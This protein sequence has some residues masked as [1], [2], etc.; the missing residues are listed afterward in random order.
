MACC[1]TRPYEIVRLTPEVRPNRCLL[2][3]KQ[4]TPMWVD[5]PPGP[6]HGGGTGRSSSSPL[7]GSCLASGLRRRDLSEWTTQ[8]HCTRPPKEVGECGSSPQA[9]TPRPYEGERRVRP[10]PGRP[11]PVYA[12]PPRTGERRDGSERRSRTPSAAPTRA[13]ATPTTPS[14]EARRQP[15]PQQA[16]T[17]GAAG[18][19]CPCGTCACSWSSEPKNLCSLCN[20][21]AQRTAITCLCPSLRAGPWAEISFNVR[22]SS[23][24]RLPPCVGRPSL[25]LTLSPMDSYRL[26]LWRQGLDLACCHQVEHCIIGSSLRA[27]EGGAT[28]AAALG[29][30]P[31]VRR[32]HGDQLPVRRVLYSVCFARQS[33]TWAAARSRRRPGQAAAARIHAPP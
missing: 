5:R 8:F 4:T 26:A 19:N 20:A 23:V 21:A 22:R 9:P 10:F 14:S 18:Q 6:V 3:S 7:G 30:R 29:R 15:A 12:L 28:L 2:R 11:Y 17:A 16:G 25:V 27:A 13:I 32:H 1:C 31:A 24:S 33:P